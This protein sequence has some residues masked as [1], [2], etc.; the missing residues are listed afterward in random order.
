[1]FLS[2]KNVPTRCSR[3]FLWF[4]LS[5]TYYAGRIYWKHGAIE[6]KKKKRNKFVI[7]VSTYLKFKML[8]V[9]IFVGYFVAVE[10]PELQLSSH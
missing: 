5:F 9:A 3:L 6:K 2:Q 4:R 7:Y 10:P 8:H 1:M